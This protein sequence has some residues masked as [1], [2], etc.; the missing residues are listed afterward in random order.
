MRTL[1]L[2]LRLRLRLRPRD[3]Q[4][5]QPIDCLLRLHLDPSQQL[6]ARRYVLDEPQHDPRGPDA[7]LGVPRLVHQP[8]TLAGNELP[9]VL[10]L[11]A[12]GTALER[13][14]LLPEDEE[15]VAVIAGGTWSV[16]QRT[17]R[18]MTALAG[19]EG[20]WMQ[21]TRS[22]M[23]RTARMF[24]WRVVRIE[25]VLRRT[26]IP[27]EAATVSRAGIEAENTNEVPLIR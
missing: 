4:P 10:E 21:S 19:C 1:Q 18:W 24:S 2:R 15:P 22:R 9:D 26:L 20:M 23:A 11:G 17:W 14:D 16:G 8:A 12:P 6:L 3:A 27:S 13:D 7:A 25:G 5:H